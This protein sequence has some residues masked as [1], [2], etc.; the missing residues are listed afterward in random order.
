MNSIRKGLKTLTGV[1][2]VEPDNISGTVTVDFD[3]SQVTQQTLAQKLS[4]MGYPLSGENSLGKKA[5]SYVSCMIG[6]VTD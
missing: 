3:E 6:R 5:K 2:T 4:D 1:E